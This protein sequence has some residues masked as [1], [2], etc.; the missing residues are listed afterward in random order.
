MTIDLCGIIVYL[1][2]IFIGITKAR[3]AAAG[4]WDYVCLDQYTIRPSRH[5]VRIKPMRIINQVK[6]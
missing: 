2:T 6:L 4:K 5:E 3:K 1:P